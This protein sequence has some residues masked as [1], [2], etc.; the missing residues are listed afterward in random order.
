[1]STTEQTP[2]NQQ[3]E[4]EVIVRRHDWDV[5]AIF[6]NAGISGT[7]GRDK[8]PGYDRLCKG[9]ARREFDL[10]AAWSVDRRLWLRRISRRPR[11]FRTFASLTQLTTASAAH[12]SHSAK[13]S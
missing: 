6:V 5:V 2:E 10:V 7:K 4:L 13:S 1:L 11:A 12:L 3:R 8:R 9:V